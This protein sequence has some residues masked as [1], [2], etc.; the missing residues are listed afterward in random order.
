[1]LDGI[2]YSA[3][4]IAYNGQ[5]IVGRDLSIT[6]SG[7]LMTVL[8]QAGLSLYFLVVIKF[9]KSFVPLLPE[10]RRD[11]VINRFALLVRVMWM[12]PLLSIV[13]AVMPG[14]CLVYQRSWKIFSRIYLIGSGVNAGL[15]GSLL[16]AAIRLVL[17]E[18]K[19]HVILSPQNSEGVLLVIRR[20]NSAHRVI[21]IN[22]VTLMLAAILFGAY[23]FLM[24]RV[25]LMF[26]YLELT[27]PIA[28]TILV[29]TVSKK[30]VQLTQEDVEVAA[31]EIYSVIKKNLSVTLIMPFFPSTRQALKIVPAIASDIDETGSQSGTSPYL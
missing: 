23:D 6:I 21:V 19:S 13:F 30:P 7:C 18:L 28:G 24:R 10:E 27:C 15:Y 11:R 2:F 12:V 3:N 5:N 29:L 20:L 17:F 9:L 4:K 14:L 22:S 1:M 31:N 16:I 8:G 26:M 25:I